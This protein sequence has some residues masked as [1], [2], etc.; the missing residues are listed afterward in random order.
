MN[1]AVRQIRLLRWVLP[2]G[3]MLVLVTWAVSLRWGVGYFGPN[4][5]WGFNDGYAGFGWYG[6]HTGIPEFWHAQEAGGHFGFILPSIDRFAGGGPAVIIPFWL[7]FLAFALPTACL[8]RTNPR[9]EAEIHSTNK[10]LLIVSL[11]AVIF[12]KVSLGRGNQTTDWTLWDLAAMLWL[13]L[14]SFLAARGQPF[15]PLHFAF[16]SLGAL[17]IVVRYKALV[18][19][20][21]A[22]AGAGVCVV[23]AAWLI[24]SIVMGC[25][26]R[27]TASIGTRPKRHPQFSC[28]CGYSLMGNVSGVCPECGRSV[29]DE[30]PAS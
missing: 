26:C 10:G 5:F 29:G 1:R 16:G 2:A 20:G 9:S 30:N 22:S 3:C 19:V 25:V 18:Q 11:L 15:K 6:G 21:V 17:I 12:I 4:G 23:A 28:T 24:S 27:F 8:R 7:L 14:T 13:P